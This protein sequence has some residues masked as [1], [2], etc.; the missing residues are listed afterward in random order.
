MRPYRIFLVFVLGTFLCNIGP[1]TLASTSQI[2]Q[3]GVFDGSESE[4]LP[5][6]VPELGYV[7]DHDFVCDVSEP[8]PRQIWQ[9]GVFDDTRDEYLQGQATDTD[10]LCDSPD[11]TNGTLGPF[12]VGVTPEHRFPSVIRSPD[13]STGFALYVQSCNS[14]TIEF[15]VIHN[16]TNVELRYRRMGGEK[17]AIYLDGA[18]IGVAGP[19]TVDPF[20]PTDYVLPIGIL[21]DGSHTIRIV[22]LPRPP[23]T[24]GTSCQPDGKMDGYHY[25]DALELTGDIEYFGTAEEFVIGVTPDDRFPARIRSS[26]ASSSFLLSA[27]SARSVTIRFAVSDAYDDV[28]LRYTHMGA[29]KDAVMFDGVTV[30]T[31]GP[32]PTDPFGPIDY[33]LPIGYVTPGT[34]AVQIVGMERQPCSGGN[35]CQADGLSDGYHNVDAL[36][37]TG[38]LAVGAIAGTVT[39]DCPTAGTALLGVAVDAYEIGTGDFVASDTTDVNGAFGLPDLAAGEYTVTVVTPLSYTTSL[40]DIVA[41][42]TGGVTTPVDFSLSCIEMLANTRGAGFWKHQ[43]GVATG[44]NGRAQVDAATLCNYLDLIEVHFNSNAINQVTVYAPPISNECSDKLLV[45][46]DLLNLKGNVGMTA[47]AKQQLM[48]LLLNVACSNLSLRAIVSADG[49]TASQAITYCDNIIDDPAGDHELAKDLGEWINDGQEVTGGLIPLDTDDIAYSPPRPE[50]R[51]HA[52]FSLSRIYPNPFNPSTLI[53]YSIARS[54]LVKLRIYDVNGGLVRSLVSGPQ[55]AGEHA[56][57]WEGTDANGAPAV[58]GV[59]FVRLESA[60]QVQTRKIVLLK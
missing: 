13:A 2:W 54:D 45:A 60:G 39:A 14:V 8:V 22:G 33:L 19:Q 35:S 42:V 50:E 32:Q 40:P 26:D 21:A 17:D 41:T 49:A 27:H 44:G 1:P 23:C 59:Y 56:A 53:E 36:E 29:E 38:V 52:V 25:V 24:G 55:N 48:A 51:P 11:G 46:K 58:S 9:I 37:L 31:T 15:D 3:I 18:Q 7:Q 4:Y 28:V 57:T 20:A 43:V 30:G 47:R 6:E 16:Y 34:H 10:F 5:G 12:V